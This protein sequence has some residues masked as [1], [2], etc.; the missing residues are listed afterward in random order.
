MIE[1]AV[2]RLGNAIVGN[3]LVLSTCSDKC[4]TAYVPARVAKDSAELSYV[5]YRL[6]HTPSP[7]ALLGAFGPLE[8]WHESTEIGQAL[9][10]LH[11]AITGG[12]K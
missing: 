11:K 6:I 5:L 4:E 7:A 1:E 2:A 8:E 12:A 3:S 9:R 10:R